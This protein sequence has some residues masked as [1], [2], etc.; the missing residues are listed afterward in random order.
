M[1]PSNQ[2]YGQPDQVCRYGIPCFLAINLDPEICGQPD[3][4]CVTGSHS[5]WGRAVPVNAPTSLQE[6]WPDSVNGTETGG[7]GVPVNCPHNTSLLD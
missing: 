3:F 7:G 5:A 4:A 6:I 2:T 1:L